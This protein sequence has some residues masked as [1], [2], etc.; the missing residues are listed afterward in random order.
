MIS[1]AIH[2]KK[3]VLC[4]L[5]LLLFVLTYFR[6]DRKIFTPGLKEVEI[7]NGNEKFTF[8][9]EVLDI[10]DGANNAR[11]SS[12][13]DPNT[14]DIIK[15]DTS[16]LFHIVTTFIPFDNEEIR[17]NLLIN[18]DQLPTN[19]ELEARMAEVVACLQKNLNHELVA[20]VHLLV[21]RDGAIAYLQSLNLKRSHKLIIHKMDETPTMLH[22]L[23]YAS[24]YLQGKMA[25]VSHQDNYI[26]EGWEKVDHNI[27]K[28][29]HLMYA[30][31]RHIPPSKCPATLRAA[32]CGENNLYLGSHDTFVFYVNGSLARHKLVEI[33][34]TPNTS[35]VENVLIWIFKERF[36]YRVLNPCKVLIVYHMHCVPIREM[37]RE[38]IN[39]RGK[40]ALVYFTYQL[41]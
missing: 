31:T 23:M 19:Q 15:A 40:N 1:V 21:F 12:A 6:A 24:K 36:K 7:R 28:R 5:V 10:L 8:A 34:V 27:L 39:V 32:N 33:D 38:R 17:K 35:G 9:Y 25:I 3:L 37:G 20:F 41:Q 16:G 18:E 26:G 14:R 30:L 29:E 11:M 2:W 4:T 22:E 13:V